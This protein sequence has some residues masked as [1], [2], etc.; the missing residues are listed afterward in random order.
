MNAARPSFRDV[1]PGFGWP[2]AIVVAAILLQIVASASLII[3]FLLTKDTCKPDHCEA[4]RFIGLAHL[5]EESFLRV[6]KDD[7]SRYM[8][9]NVFAPAAYMYMAT[10]VLL[11]GLFIARV[12]RFLTFRGKL[13]LVFTAFLAGY[14]Y[15]LFTTLV[16]PPW[17]DGLTQLHRG[18]LAGSTAAYFIMFCAFPL[19][20]ILLVASFSCGTNDRST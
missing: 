3:Y 11:L 16:V 7:G 9:Y 15:Y 8:F 12:R 17:H 18:V 13:K 5:N 20:S 4:I 14:L 19:M 1:L 6:L 2:E 10:T